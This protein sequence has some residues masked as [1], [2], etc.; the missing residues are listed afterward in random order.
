[1]GCRWDKAAMGKG[2]PVRQ[3]ATRMGCHGDRAATVTVAD[4]KMGLGWDTASLVPAQWH[5]ERVN[6]TS[7]APHLALRCSQPAPMGKGP[8]S[9]DVFRGRTHGPTYA[10]G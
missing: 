10:L 5:G 1:M 7:C 8:R 3:G 6:P 4:A 2:L 9:T